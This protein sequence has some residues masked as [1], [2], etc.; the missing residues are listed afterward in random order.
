MEAKLA[1]VQW[2]YAT[3]GQTKGP[4]GEDK[5]RSLI[6]SGKVSPTDGVW[7]AGL[8]AW[9]PAKSIEGLVPK[10][11][12]PPPPPPASAVADVVFFMEK[13]WGIASTF[14]AILSSEVLKVYIERRS[15]ARPR[16]RA[17]STTP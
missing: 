9:V 16:R 8:A 11:A 1:E 6:A 4:V 17:A 3:D 2:H 13:G 5:L 10:K 12:A 15:W 7:R 14:A